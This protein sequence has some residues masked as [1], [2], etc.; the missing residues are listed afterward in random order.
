MPSRKYWHVTGVRSA[1]EN[2]DVQ[3]TQPVAKCSVVKGACPLS[4]EEELLSF[5]D[6]VSVN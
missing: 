2:S 3:D 4:Q 6:L 1:C 5:E